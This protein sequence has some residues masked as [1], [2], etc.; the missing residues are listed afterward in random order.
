M[1]LTAIWVCPSSCT[2][3]L[4]VPSDGCWRGEVGSTVG[5]EAHWH[6]FSRTPEATGGWLCLIMHVSQAYHILIRQFSLWLLYAHLWL[7]CLFRSEEVLPYLFFV[8]RRPVWEE[9]KGLNWPSLVC[10]VIRIVQLM[11]RRYTLPIQKNMLCCSGCN[12]RRE[13]SSDKCISAFTFA[14]AYLQLLYFTKLLSQLPFSL[15]PNSHLM[16][17][18]K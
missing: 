16:L 14:H 18:L 1:C 4:P 10:L 17:H 15:W 2:E 8:I 9:L 11:I 7:L 5:G 6:P 13:A 12:N 3:A